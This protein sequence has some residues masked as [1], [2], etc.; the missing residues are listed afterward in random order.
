MRVLLIT[1]SARGHAIAEALHRSP[2]KPEIISICVNRNPGI[3]TLASEMYIQNLME[4]DKIVEVAKKTTPDFAVIGPDDPIG[5]GLAD[6]L[7]EIGLPCVAPK[8]SLARV[9]SSKGFTRQ[10]LQKYGIDS[11]PEFRVFELN[12]QLARAVVFFRDAVIADI[13]LALQ[14]F[15]H[16]NAVF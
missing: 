9:E 14:H 4:F 2:Q 15:Q 13:S 1:S 3:R 5:G 7:E 12:T 8:K 16:V 6:V 11:S 10:L